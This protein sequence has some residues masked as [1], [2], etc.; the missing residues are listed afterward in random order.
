MLLLGSCA[1]G[2]QLVGSMRVPLYAC[3]Y[4]YAQVVFLYIQ[5]P[6]KR[7]TWNTKHVMPFKGTKHVMSFK[8][9]AVQGAEHA[10]VA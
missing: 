10:E 6:Y 2:H 8:G 3:T 5:P 9:N 4:L 1:F 7:M